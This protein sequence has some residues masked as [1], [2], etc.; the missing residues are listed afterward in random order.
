M[1]KEIDFQSVQGTMLIPLLGR[2]YESKNNKD[3]LDD[4]EAVQIIKNC[5]F[6]FSN[7]SN[8]FGEY[9]CITYIAPARK[10]DDTIR[11]FIR[12]RPNATIVNIGSRLD[13]TFSRAD[14]ENQP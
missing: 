12:K 6:D 2:A 10:I 3:I 7:I 8:T 14:N 13:T 9:G 1:V 5:D 11:Q 4:K